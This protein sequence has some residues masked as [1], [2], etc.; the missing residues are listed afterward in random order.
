MSL[1]PCSIMFPQPQPRKDGKLLGHHGAEHQWGR[2]AANTKWDTQEQAFGKRNCQ[3]TH[4]DG[5][6]EAPQ[7]VI[8]VVLSGPRCPIC[9]GRLDNLFEI[10]GG[11]RMVSHL[12]PLRSPHL[13]APVAKLRVRGSRVP[14]APPAHALQAD[15]LIQLPARFHQGHIIV[16]IP[17]WGG[18][19]A[20]LQLSLA[21]T[22]PSR[23]AQTRGTR[24]PALQGTEPLPDVQVQL[25][26]A[27]VLDLTV[28]RTERRVQV[29]PCPV[30]GRGQ[31]LSLGFLLWK[32]GTGPA[33]R[34]PGAGTETTYGHSCPRIS[35]HH[36]RPRLATPPPN[37]TRSLTRGSAP[38]TRG[39][40]CCS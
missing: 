35:W 40:G 6:V 29:M 27:H 2:T 17:G 4:P 16:V 33:L 31:F 19:L 13:L 15:D 3:P 36:R 5:Y 22:A 11:S 9:A 12:W 26:C 39:S 34:F 24:T 18:G 23:S 25:V 30:L 1:P 37:Q 21:L 32:V 8:S 7:E 20:C 38:S 14:P 28:R 10:P